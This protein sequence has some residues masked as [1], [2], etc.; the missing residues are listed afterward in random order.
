LAAWEGKYL[1]QLM[2]A[3]VSYGSCPTCEIPKGRPMRHSPFR[4]LDNSRD[5]HIYSDQLDDNHIDTLD[6]L[7]VHTI[8]T[9]FWE[10][11]LSNVYRLSQPDEL[12]Q[13]PLGFVRDLLHWLLK[14]LKARNVKDQFDNGFTWV[15]Q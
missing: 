11:L 14:N 2:I 15:P 8:H 6:T 12:H 4:P 9:Q 5:Q 3:Q 1:E 13:L 10:Y 7:G